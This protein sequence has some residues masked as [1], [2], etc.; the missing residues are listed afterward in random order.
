MGVGASQ[1]HRVS[2]AWVSWL[3]SDPLATTSSPSGTVTAK[4]KPARSRGWSLT[5][6]QVAATWGWPAT[7][8][9]SSVRMNPPHPSAWSQERGSGTPS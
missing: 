4:L 5:G 6:N 2:P 1:T 9:P 8:T 3:S 7:S